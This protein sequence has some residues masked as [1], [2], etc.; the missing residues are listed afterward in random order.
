MASNVLLTLALFFMGSCTAESASIEPVTRPSAAGT[1]QAKAFIHLVDG[2]A[3]VK[4]A[5]GFSF[6]AKPGLVLLK[7]DEVRAADDGFVVLR[8]PNGYLVRIDAEVSLLI[9]DIIVLEAD[10][11]DSDFGQ[12]L[13]KL[14]TKKEKQKGERIAGWHARLTGAQTI[15]PQLDEESGP[16]T[17]V[18]RPVPVSEVELKGLGTSDRKSTRKRSG[19]RLLMKT[20]P[21]G[22]VPDQSKKG[23]KKPGGDKLA[24]SANS[25]AIAP[26]EK[27]EAKPIAWQTRVAGKLVAQTKNLPPLAA[28]IANDPELLSCIKM[29]VSKLGVKVQ[30]VKIMIQLTNHKVYRILLGGG[31]SAPQCL[32]AKY[33]Q[34]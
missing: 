14:L 25:D 21:K 4:S 8:L 13:G 31:L 15:P 6:E 18:A 7:T 33:N 5:N 9:A 28:K 3:Q 2:K 26:P 24:E 27:K 22:P 30:K 34:K 11:T 29:A 20:P 17:K 23:E 12:Q 16:A 19:K 10:K 32:P 1:G